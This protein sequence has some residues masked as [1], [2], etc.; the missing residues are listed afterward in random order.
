MRHAK[1]SCSLRPSEKVHLHHHGS[2]KMDLDLQSTIF[3]LKE[4]S[5][6]LLGQ[7]KED[8]LWS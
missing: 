8:Q 1:L 2:N 3:S 6:N 4:D 5:D 7:V